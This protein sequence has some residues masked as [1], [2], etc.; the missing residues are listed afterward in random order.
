MSVTFTLQ[1]PSTVQIL[2]SIGA[3]T[4]NPTAGYY[5]DVDAVIYVN[6]AY[7][8]QGGWN[9]IQ[10]GNFA[11]NPSLHAVSINT[12]TALPA[13]TH[14]IDLRTRR[15]LGNVGVDIGGN[16]ALDVNPGE[17]TVVIFEGTGTRVLLSD[18]DPRQPRN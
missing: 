1:S 6:D 4:T 8:P 9:R 18:K 3:L 7:L 13:G 5:A 15:V 11:S 16:A 14:T 17:L 12:V 10:I 2:A